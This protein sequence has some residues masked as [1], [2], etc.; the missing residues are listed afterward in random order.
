MVES[1]LDRLPGGGEG[2][3]VGDQQ[4][5]F[6]AKLLP[7]HLGGPAQHAIAQFEAAGF[8]GSAQGFCE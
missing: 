3:S 4:G 7:E 8:A 5:R 6:A 2:I 1:L